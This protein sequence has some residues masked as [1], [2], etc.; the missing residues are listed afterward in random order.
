MT[1]RRPWDAEDGA[2]LVAVFRSQA[3]EAQVTLVLCWVVLV[4]ILVRSVIA[5]SHAGG[6]LQ[7]RVLVVGTAELAAT[8]LLIREQ[9]VACRGGARFRL[10]WAPPV[11]LVLAVIPLFWG[12]ISLGIV[13]A[14]AA[15]I[16][17]YP[18]LRAA[19]LCLGLGGVVAL[20]LPDDQPLSAFGLLV[21][22]GLLLVIVLA[23]TVLAVRM[24]RL[25]LTKEVLA[26]RQVDAERDR[27]ARDLHDIMGRTLVA[28]SLRNQTALRLLGPEDE[29]TKPLLERLHDTL[30]AGQVQLRALTNGPTIAD[31]EGE[32]AGAKALCARVNIDLII[33]LKRQP[34][35]SLDALL[36]LV[37][38]ES[39]TNVLKHSHA[40]WCRIT[41]DRDGD[42]VAVTITNNGVRKKVAGAPDAAVD[43]RL[44][45]AVVAAGGTIRQG[46]LESDTY[47]SAIRIPIRDRMHSRGDVQ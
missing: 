24:D 28:A 33:D 46:A 3:R 41:L 30:S 44:A 34:P 1:L 39:I 19:I 26:R 38:R 36:G 15:V 17:H 18:P 35:G 16:L 22:I 45:R 43:S 8:A 32:F 5:S 25:H 14:S 7:P 20:G 42:A 40:S 29:G 2:S 4:A 23:V 13:Y 11:M 27:V 9:L 47:E 12:V 6:F 21:E 10:A 31:L 37:V